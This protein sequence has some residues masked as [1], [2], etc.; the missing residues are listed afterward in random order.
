M[1]QVKYLKTNKKISSAY[2]CPQKDYCFRW[3]VGWGEESRGKHEK[4][5][6]GK[7]ER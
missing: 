6:S 4:T 1:P 5:N 3:W 2:R 7:G